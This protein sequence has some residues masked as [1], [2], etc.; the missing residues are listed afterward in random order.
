MSTFFACHTC[1]QEQAEEAVE[2]RAEREE[3]IYGG[4]SKNEPKPELNKVKWGLTEVAMWNHVE[5]SEKR[6]GSYLLNALS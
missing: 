5:A 4:E 1:E 2:R 3:K 6:I